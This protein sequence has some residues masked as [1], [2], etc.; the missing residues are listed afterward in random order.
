MKRSYL[1]LLTLLCA[2]YTSVFGQAPALFNYQGVA[3]NPVGN[4]L[5]NKNITVRLTIHDGTA[6]GPSVYSETRTMTTNAFG[7]FNILVGSAGAS[8]V[9]GTIPG[10]NWLVGDKFLQVEIDPEGGAAFINVGSSQLASVPY[11]FT[12]GTATPGGPAGGDLS[13]TYPNPGVARIQ[14][15]PVANVAPA[16]GQALVWSTVNSRWEPG[17]ALPSGPA[18]GDLSGTYPNPTVS[19]LQGRPFTNVAPANGQT[20]VWNGTTNTWEPGNGAA[21]SLVLPFI[22][23]QNKAGTLFSI[24]NNGDGTSI[25]GVNNTTTSSIA[26]IRGIV[27]STAPGGFSSALRG[28]NN[29]TGG[30]GIGVWGS[31]NGSGW[32]VYGSTPNGL[33]VY[34]N[35]TGTGYGVYGNSNN[36]T[37]IAGT[38]NNG[39]SGY[40]FNSNIANANPTLQASNSGDGPAID[41]ETSS[42]ASSITAVRGIVSSTAPGGFS[43]AVRGINNGAGGLGIGVWGSQNGTGWGVYGVTPNGLGVYGNSSGNGTGVYANS[44]TGTGLNATSNSGVAAQVSISNN[45][46]NN[47]VLMANT[48][49]NGNGIDVTLPA[50][51]SARGVNVQAGAGPGV[52]SVATGNAVWGV[53]TNISSAGVIGDNSVGEAV[54]GRSQGGNGVGAVVGRNDN[55]GYG[56]RGFNTSSGI[57]VLGQASIA[58]TGRAARFENLNT[59]NN[60]AAVEVG[61]S[62]IGVGIS[63]QLTNSGSGAR[64]IDVS[65]SGVG[66]GVFA[67]GAGHAIWGVTTSISSAGVLGDNATGEAVVGRSQGGNGVGAVVGRN[68]N[69]GYGVRGF[70]TSSGIGVLGQAGISGGTGIGGRFENVNAANTSNALEAITNGGGLALRASAGN[71]AANIAVFQQ[72][73][74]N[75]VRIDAAGQVFA[76]GGFTTGGADVAEYFDITGDRNAYEPGDV[77][78]ISQSADRTVEKSSGAYS[79]LVSGVYATKPGMLLTEKNAVDDDLSHMVPMGVI[80]VIPTKVCLEGGAIRRGDLI[81]TSSIPGVAMKGDPEKVKIG[82]VMGKALQDYNANEVGKINVLVSVK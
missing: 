34:G 7:L 55:A 11:A 37:G 70:N 40:F 20:I 18:G 24:T 45:A 78:V 74:G 10:V 16:A 66:P 56:V 77:L 59:G 65:N 52:F 41:G 30:L 19:R 28:I 58:S 68:D 62:G 44:N 33:S 64:G 1:L 22:T 81:V 25:E 8:N 50:G 42:S 61:H 9:T 69:A 36:G 3:R 6:S 75:R 54:V 46:N 73:G 39:V 13:G 23:T 26:A 14:G 71:S 21:T 79:S 15:R 76:N 63:V 51:S 17:A 67:S 27:S 12:A 29:G 2:A 53:T 82:Q 5:A 43:S 47:T 38:S 80:G 35:A 48:S 32:G 72:N 31:Q 4:V 60:S 57:G 49:G